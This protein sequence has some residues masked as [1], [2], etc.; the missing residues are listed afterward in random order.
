MHGEDHTRDEENTALKAMTAP[1]DQ[2]PC[3]PGRGFACGPSL[4]LGGKEYD[5]RLC[6]GLIPDPDDE[7]CMLNGYVD[8]EEGKVNVSTKGSFGTFIDTMWH[9]FCHMID[10]EYH[11]GLTEKQIM[12]LGSGL[13]ALAGQN[14]QLFQSVNKGMI[15]LYNETADC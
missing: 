10:R 14:R 7:N 11:I 9:E 15:A 8:I 3:T 1:I 2:R 5:V 4:R 13:S 6:K 12:Q